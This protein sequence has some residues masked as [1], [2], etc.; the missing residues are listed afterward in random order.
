[1]DYD[2]LKSSYWTQQAQRVEALRRA[3][4]ERSQVRPGRLIPDDGDVA[5]GSGRRLD[6]AVLFLDLVTGRSRRSALRHYVGL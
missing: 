2:G 6:L 4:N 5:I 3:I 1:M